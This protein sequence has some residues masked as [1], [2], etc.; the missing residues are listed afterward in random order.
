MKYLTCHN[1][2]YTDSPCVPE[3]YRLDNGAVA[4]I[5]P[6]YKNVYDAY[7]ELNTE[8]NELLKQNLKLKQMLNK[9]ISVTWGEGWN[10]SLQVRV[11]AEKL[12]RESK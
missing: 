11:E 1:C 10:Y 3:D 6:N 7:V 4:E 12:L 9:A 2:L 5:C 8:N